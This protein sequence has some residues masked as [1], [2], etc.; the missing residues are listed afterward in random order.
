M[1]SFHIFNNQ[2]AFPVLS[3]VTTGCSHL[4][5]LNFKSF[6]DND[7]SFSFVKTVREEILSENFTLEP[8]KQSVITITTTIKAK[9]LYISDYKSRR[10]TKILL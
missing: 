6:P 8:V 2:S 1:I 4:Y 9:R 3:L 10:K 7:R 5:C